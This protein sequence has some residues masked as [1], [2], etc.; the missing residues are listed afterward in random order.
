[1]RFT[2]FR[3]NRR[4]V[5]VIE[6][7]LT[8]PLVAIGLAAATDYG[9]REWSRSC[10]ANAVAQ[11]AY[12]AFRTGP[13][14]NP[15][16]V[17]ALVV[18]TSSLTG[19]TFNGRNIAPVASYCPSGSPTPSLKPPPSDGSTCSDGSTPG[20]YLVITAYYPLTPIIP[21]YSGLSGQSI[22]ETATV[23]LQ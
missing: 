9:L 10:L 3:N 23:R 7:A 20:K 16:N 12:Y 6:F 11:G 21:S 15:A 5:A 4:A 22:S 18:G 17:Q 13:S 14:V 19:V 2:A 8:A 1:M